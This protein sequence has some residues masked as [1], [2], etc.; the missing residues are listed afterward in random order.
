M[1]CAVNNIVI[2]DEL[3]SST[4][5]SMHSETGWQFLWCPEYIAKWEVSADFGFEGWYTWGGGEK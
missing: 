3:S 1:E 2:L 4:I 5:G